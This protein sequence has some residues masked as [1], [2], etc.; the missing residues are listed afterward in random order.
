MAK[1]SGAAWPEDCG[2]DRARRAVWSRS[3]DPEIPIKRE[4]FPSEWF[5]M[6]NKQRSGPDQDSA[7]SPIGPQDD[8]P[9]Q[10]G[11]DGRARSNHG[12]A[13]TMCPSDDQEERDEPG[14][15]PVHARPA[16]SH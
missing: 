4:S 11:A 9:S 14:V 13:A 5:I 12:L 16:G 8:A 1:P 7:L 15:E 6:S 2:P 10:Q 3:R